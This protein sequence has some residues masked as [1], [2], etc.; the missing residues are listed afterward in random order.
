M[1]TTFSDLQLRRKMPKLTRRISTI[2]FKNYDVFVRIFSSM[3]PFP[4]V[5]FAFEWD[6]GEDDRPFRLWLV[7]LFPEATK[8]SWLKLQESPLEHCSC[9]FHWKHSHLLKE[10]FVSI[11]T[12]GDWTLFQNTFPESKASD[13]HHLINMKFH[14]SQFSFVDSSVSH[15]FEQLLDHTMPSQSEIGRNSVILTCTI[16][17]W[18][19]L[20]AFLSLIIVHDPSH[21]TSK[22]WTSSL[23]KLKVNR[24]ASPCTAQ[25]ALACTEILE[26]LYVICLLVIIGRNFELVAL[27]T[28]TLLRKVDCV[29]M[30]YFKDDAIIESSIFENQENYVCCLVIDCD[31]TSSSIDWATSTSLIHS[32]VTWGSAVRKLTSV[33]KLSLQLW[34]SI[35]SGNL[36]R[37]YSV[38]GTLGQSIIQTWE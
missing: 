2:F 35:D 20:K 32:M 3:S 37:F 16:L 22:S 10:G 26:D 38:I 11:L 25:W 36:P 31:V 17:P 30:S 24:S 1:N 9:A 28:L 34:N 21:L 13:S 4:S 14:C 19:G 6:A 27:S 33:L 8:G 29:L 5:C 7:P 23:C 15:C 12:L 18:W